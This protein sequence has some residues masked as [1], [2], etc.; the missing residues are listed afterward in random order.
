M[1]FSAKPDHFTLTARAVAASIS[2]ASSHGIDVDEPDAS[3]YS[4]RVHL[5]PMPIVAR[6]STITPILRSPIDSW[7][8][9]EIQVAQFLAS[10]G[11]PVVAPSDLLPAKPYHCD[12]MTMTFWHY[13]KPIANIVPDS[14]MIG[15]MLAEL[16]A[17]LR[18]Y[19]GDLPLLVAP[20]ND[21]PC[22]LE[23]LEQRGNI[24][25]ESDLK[26]LQETYNHLQP[27]LSNPTA[28]LQP[29]HGDAHALNLIPTAK[30]WLWNDFEDTCKGPIAWDWINL[31]E[32]GRAAY[33]QT[34]DPTLLELYTQVRKLHAIVWVYAMLPEFSD[35]V[36]SANTLLNELKD[37]MKKS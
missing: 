37:K 31:K 8:T 19:P 7:L 34:P 11:A 9:H 22:G 10:V 14:A 12:G 3:A 33:P 36:E 6:V 29:L 4:V 21:I 2:V 24:I 35:W 28:S 1:S 32:E 15:G 5:R 23:R 26:L 18:K 27:Q 30:G 25:S 20:L 17:A 16:H 13:V